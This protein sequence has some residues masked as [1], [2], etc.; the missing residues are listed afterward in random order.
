MQSRESS[1]DDEEDGE[2]DAMKDDDGS[3][4]EAM[5]DDDASNA[6][7]DVGPHPTTAKEIEEEGAAVKKVR[8]Q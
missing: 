2:D 5:E 1:D 3:D 4:D 6:M 8:E 7:E